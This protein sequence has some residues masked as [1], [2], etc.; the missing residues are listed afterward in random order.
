MRELLDY[1][2]AL[3]IVGTLSFA[4]GFGVGTLR[5]K[6]FLRRAAWKAKIDWELRDPE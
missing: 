3:T 4:V 5:A 6:F 2:V 1:L